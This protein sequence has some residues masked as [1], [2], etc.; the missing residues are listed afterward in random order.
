MMRTLILLLAV[1]ASGAEQ[2]HFAYADATT[3][4]GTETAASNLMKLVFALHVPGNQANADKRDDWTSIGSGFFVQGTNQVLL[5]ITCNHILDQA[6]KMKRQVF[7]GIDLPE[8]YQRF[9]A[10][11]IHTDTNND[12]AVIASVASDPMREKLKQST[13]GSMFFDDGSSLVE[14]RGVLMIGYPLSLGTEDDKNHPVV[15]FGMIAQNTGRNTF[16]IDGSANRGNSGSPVVTLMYKG[17]RLSGMITSFMN[18]RINLHDENG[19]LTAQFP[20]NAGL[21]RAIKASVILDAMAEAN[22]KIAA[23]GV[24]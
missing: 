18:D 16:L 15:R 1:A 17:S 22:K 20:Y 3:F 9:R 12:V 7:V 14:G 24:R 2:R 21:A 13:F 8:G 6:A 11:T 4:L 23:G 19:N 5:G 10:Q